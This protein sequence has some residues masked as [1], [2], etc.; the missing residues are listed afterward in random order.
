MHFRREEESSS[1]SIYLCNL[2]LAI[3][4]LLTIISRYIPSKNNSDF[5]TVVSKSNGK[6]NAKVAAHQH[7]SNCS[8]KD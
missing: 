8:S 4:C 7:Y 5:C 2:R 1:K 6:A 3:W